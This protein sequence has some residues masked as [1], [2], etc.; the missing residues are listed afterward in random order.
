MLPPPPP[1]VALINLCSFCRYS[2]LRAYVLQRFDMRAVSDE[3]SKNS[4]RTSHFE[5]LCVSYLG[6]KYEDLETSF[7]TVKAKRWCHSVADGYSKKGRLL[8]Y[9]QGCRIKGHFLPVKGRLKPCPYLPLGTTPSDKIIYGETYNLKISSL[10]TSIGASG[11]S[12]E[13]RLVISK[14]S[15]SASLKGTW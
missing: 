7:N 5:Y 4:I 6:S 3:F 12:M 2:L 13:T 9:C 15:T 14:Q 1:G 10:R 8:V 11:R